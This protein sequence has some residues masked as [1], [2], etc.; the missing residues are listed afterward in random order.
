[1]EATTYLTTSWDDGHP[2]DFRVAEL[3]GKYGLQGTFYVP[4]SAPAGTMPAARLR[5][6]SATFEIG[7][8]TLHHLDLTRAPED[9]VRREIVDSKAWIEDCTGKPCRMFCPPKGRYARRHLPLIR[10]AGYLGVRTVELLSVRFPR[11]RAGVLLQPTTLQA[12]PHGPCAYVRNLV[13]RGAFRNL[14]QFLVHG[15]AADWPTLARSLLDLA[16]RR[17]GV[18]HLWGH[19]WELEETGQWQRLEEVLR[20]L[21]G[22]TD[23]APA[24]TNGQVCQAVPAAGGGPSP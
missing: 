18:F 23:R 19:S 9:Q 4:R 12:H 8:H 24:L 2:L 6:L 16:L 13:K 20:F 5:E 15:R 17:G 11:P 7:A 1:M 21:S 10:G 3:L 22:F 14:W